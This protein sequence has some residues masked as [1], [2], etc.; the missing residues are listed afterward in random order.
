[1]YYVSGSH[2]ADYCKTNGTHISDGTFNMTQGG[3]YTVCVFDNA[4]N[5]DTEEISTN[6]APTLEDID[7]AYMTEDTPLNIP[8]NV[9]DNETALENLLVQVTASDESLFQDIT[10][11]QNSSAISLTLTP[12]AN[13]S[14]GPV[15]FTVEVTDEDNETVNDTF[16]VTIQPE[17]D[18]PVAADDTA[19]T[20][21]EDKSI[22]INVLENDS[23][24]DGDVLSIYQTGAPAHGTTVISAGK[25]KYT[26]DENYSG[27]DSFTYTVTDGH[28]A[29]AMAT[30]YV[31]VTPS[32]MRLR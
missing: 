15:T 25:I 13:L 24:I 4:G 32:T 14:G 20:T 31:T 8:I 10:I 26:P 21:Q 22:L 30:V 18:A 3:I 27:S 23:D 5:S 9:G 7:D 17:N 2:D 19:I 6:T 12:K 29:Y 16:T 1:M 28:D 11:N